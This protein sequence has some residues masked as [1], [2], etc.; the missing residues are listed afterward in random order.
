MKLLVTFVLACSISGIAQDAQQTQQP[1]QPSGQ[2]A[3]G[4]SASAQ[5]QQK[6]IK[7]PAEYNAYMSATSQTD[8]NA[9]A[10]ALEAFLQQYPNTVVKEESL[11][12][13][14]GAYQ[15]A[16]NSAK[17]V[18]AAN[19]LLQAD[20][21]N[22]RALALLV[23]TKRAQAGTLPPAQAEPVYAEAAQLAQR[24]LQAAETMPRAPG[25]SDADYKKL[26]DGVRVIFNG[27]I[28]MEA[29]QR[30]DYPAAQK[31]LA[32]AVAVPEDANNL[33]DVY[34]LATAYLQANPP[35]YTNGLWYAARA[36]DLAAQNPAAQQQ[37][38]KFALYYYKKYHGNTDG[39]DQVKQQAQASPTPPANFEI[40]KAPPP[41]TPC[42]FADTIMKNNPDVSQMAYGD[43]LFVLGSGNQK[44]ADAVWTFLNGKLVPVSSPDHPAK[45][46][47][48]T[49]DELVLATTDDDIQENKADV[50][51]KL[52]T[53]LA[54][55]KVPQPGT[56]LTTKYLGKATSYTPIPMPGA[57]NQNATG[58]QSP[59]TTQPGAAG[60][61]GT[62]AAAPGQT[63]PAAGDQTTAT[64]Q[65]AAPGQAAASGQQPTAGA[66]PC[67]NG[68]GGVMLTLT[69]GH[70]DVPVKRPAPRRGTTKRRPRH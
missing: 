7:D 69:D 3:E 41:P 4:Q 31:A 58:T 44:D 62:Q 66:S 23:Y 9:E 65:A 68:G 38:E 11:E 55:S 64:G 56:M 35:D 24:G 39:W 2:A 61:E 15:K 48:A 10:Q 1:A 70:P 20:P 18:D 59:T 6:T 27:A 45:V 36:V 63:T 12:Q 43:W 22:I 28:G 26:Q 17:M 13:L 25:V 33:Q 50:T 16:G 46:I 14:M 60:A 67:G 47:S 51:L 52:A 37:I 54:A 57:Q 30:K 5:P 53:P 40:S 21:N 32:A 34:P 19:R 29:L 49:T 8:P 42:Q